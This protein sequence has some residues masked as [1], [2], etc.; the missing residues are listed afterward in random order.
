[1]KRAFLMSITILLVAGL[2]MPVLGKGKGATRF[3]DKGV[4]TLAGSVG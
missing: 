2:A 4:I 1:M 3:G